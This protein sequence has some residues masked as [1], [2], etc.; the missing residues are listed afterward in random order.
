[1]HLTDRGRF[2]NCFV[3]MGGVGCGGGIHYKF[4]SFF[5]GEGGVGA[6]RY[7][8]ITNRP[9]P[10]K[11]LVRYQF[12]TYCSPFPPSCT[13]LIHNVPLPPPLPPEVACEFIMA[14]AALA[15]I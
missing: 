3:R 10:K 4:T 6:V 13:L 5:W 2:L 15:A 1:M 12:I 7:E 9:P 11:K 14:L 8:F